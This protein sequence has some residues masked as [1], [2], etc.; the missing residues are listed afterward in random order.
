M[1]S[2][3][4]RLKRFGA[5]IA[6]GLAMTGAAAA[7]PVVDGITVVNVTADLS[8]LSPATLGSGSV[9][10]DG[11]L[12]FPITGGDLNGL[13]GTIEHNGSGVSLSAG[14]DVLNLENFV[15][16]TTTQELLGDVSV[17]GSFVTNAALFT[18]DVTQLAQIDDLFN[19]GN[20]SL[21]LRFSAA[22]AS[23]LF[24]VFGVSGLEGEIFGLAAT[25]PRVSDVPIPAAYG[26]FVI[27]ASAVGWASRRRKRASG[28]PA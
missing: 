18:F 2:F 27:G 5:A 26:L 8:A 6:A 1:D 4:L 28:N 11:F 14:G 17:N 13:A 3:V 23:T 10:G 20:P 12:E 9:N 25:A 24:N 15:I 16:N 19:T 21:E 22:A 7:A